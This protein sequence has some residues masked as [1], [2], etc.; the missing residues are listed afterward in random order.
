MKNNMDFLKVGNYAV[1]NL[2]SMFPVPKSQCT[3]VDISKEPDSAYKALLS[4]EYRIISAMEDKIL[5][6]ATSLYEYKMKNGNETPLANRCN[7]F[8]L[9]ESKCKLFAEK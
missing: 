5:K 2:N 3:Y 8:K 1:I 7:D 6:N 4:A 9:L